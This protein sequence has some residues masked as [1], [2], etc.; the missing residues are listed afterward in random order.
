MQRHAPARLTSALC[1][2][3]SLRV[4]VNCGWGK[5]RHTHGNILGALWGRRAIAHPLATVDDNGLSSS[6]SVNALAS[7]DLKFATQNDCELV[8]IRCLPRLTPAR[9]TDH[10]CDAQA[11]GIGVHT[12]DELFYRFRRLA[13]SLDSRWCCNDS[14]H[15]AKK[16]W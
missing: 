9:W 3:T 14:W 16:W 5:G 13:V 2:G 6:N 15:V 1:R 8:K 10:A 7:L 12:T 4:A 11:L